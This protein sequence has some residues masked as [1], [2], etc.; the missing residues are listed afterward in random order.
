MAK[1][2]LQ[3]ERI[4][5]R[6]G[7][8]Q[9]MS[10]LATGGMARIYVGKDVNLEREAAVKVLTP[11]MMES[12][13]FLAERFIRE[14]KSVAVLD[15]AN[16]IP[17][18]QYGEQDGLYFLAMK[19]IKGRDLADEINAIQNT[20]ERMDIPRMLH[21]LRQT[22]AALDHAHKHGI[23][24]RDVKPS[25]VL[26]EDGTDRAILTDFGL[27]LRQ[28][29]ID[30]TM[31]TA[32]GTP[33]YISPEQALASESVVPQS[34]IYSLAIIVYEILTGSQVFKADTAMQVA[35]SHISEPPPAPTT[36][37]P[38]IPRAAE[39]EI[40]KALEKTPEARHS[41]A[42]QFI[43]AV[44]DAYGQKVVGIAGGRM[45]QTGKL[46]PEPRSPKQTASAP[47]SVP[48]IAP[49]AKKSPKSA[50]AP[51]QANTLKKSSLSI[52]IIGT[53]LVAVLALVGA[54]LALSGG[55]ESG[56]TSAGGSISPQVIPVS[57]GGQ[58]PLQAFYNREAFAIRNT[59]DV[60]VSVH[61]LRATRGN[62]TGFDGTAMVNAQRLDPG[63]CVVVQT[64][65]IRVSLPNDWGCTSVRNVI[66]RYGD[67]LFWQGE[68]G[69]FRLNPPGAGA[70]DC[71]LTDEA[72]AG[73]TCDFTLPEIRN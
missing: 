58:Q 61:Q 46:P 68:S 63:E 49:P 5:Q 14:A 38:D 48:P 12:D 7:D 67:G 17:I 70:V 71:P 30:K 31:G 60:P 28:T 73:L 65:E 6:L 11:E 24:H 25:N 57:L 37:N 36:I 16:I 23:I 39:R 34:D 27:V 50:D 52:R 45:K 33:R 40:L 62:A 44:A 64:V 69:T 13:T 21:L 56:L 32:F 51:G 72:G 29:E 19:L 47:T 42:T 3:D 4:G 10:V 55:G 59:G 43:E 53:A 2:K 22:A 18:Y 41:T 26:I 8:Y 54:F 9:I 15:H 20:G 66:L 35:L 1:K